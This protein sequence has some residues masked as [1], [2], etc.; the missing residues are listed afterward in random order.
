MNGIAMAFCYFSWGTQSFKV[1]V[2]EDAELLLPVTYDGLPDWSF[3]E[4]YIRAVE[5]VVIKDVV[6]RKDKEIKKTKE[7]VS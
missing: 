6:D 4:K 5:K 1:S 2:I 7:L 3:M